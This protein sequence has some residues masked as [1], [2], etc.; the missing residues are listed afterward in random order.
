M[1]TVEVRFEPSPSAGIIG[2]NLS[3]ATVS[4]ASGS[5]MQVD[6]PVTAARVEA[7]GVLAYDVQMSADR[8][9]YL[10]LRAYSAQT[11]SPYSNEIVIPAVAATA[12]T[13][14]ATSSTV[15]IGEETSGM[16]AGSTGTT[17]SGGTSLASASGS[18]STSGASDAS[19]PNAATST[20]SASAAAMS[21]LDFDGA[22]EFL[23]SSAAYPLG[24][25][26]EFT[27]SV[28]AV[29]DP[30][31]TGPRALVSVRGGS[32]PTQNRVELTSNGGDLALS[33]TNDAGQ[34]VYSAVWAGALAPGSWQH[35]ALSFD[36]AID[37]APML[38]VDGMI[39]APSS[40]NLTGNPAV[41]GDSAGHVFVGSSGSS[42]GTTGTWHG[43]IGHV[44]FF[45]LALG[46]DEVAEI[47]LRGHTLDLR[48]DAGAYQSGDA[49]LHYWRL[50]EDPNAV[51]YDSGSA[52]T[53]IDL[54]DPSG[55]IDAGDIVADAPVL[56]P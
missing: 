3:V 14:I 17:G 13:S 25:S 41:F 44:A 29:A 47:F 42:T 54:D 22:G 23:A 35:L 34:L 30:G 49:L 7:G 2:Y 31:A 38:A 50:G 43:A 52:P 9:H 53:P 6:I 37:A 8:P 11:F 4:G 40:A 55:Q 19:D 5:G 48:L 1:Q 20:S 39:R 15:A 24:A 32:G 36:A 18:G 16:P 33:V 26:S 51:G 10:V 46:D 56:L 28:W 45:G 27:L 12:T 21:S